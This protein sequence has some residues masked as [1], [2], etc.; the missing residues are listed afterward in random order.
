[1]RTFTQ[2]P[3]A[4][5]PATSA[6]SV[7]FSR[8]LL[9][10]R[11]DSRS[12]TSPQRTTGDQ[13]VQR[14]LEKDRRDVGGNPRFGH[15]FGR[16]SIQALPRTESG[17]AEHVTGMPSPLRAGLEA[18]SGFDL[19]GTRVHRNSP[20]PAQ[21]NALAYT[22]GQDIHLGPG[23]DEH[24]AHEGWHVVQQRQG[25]VRRTMQ[26]EGVA[27]N[28]DAGLEQEADQMASRV[29]SHGSSGP[30]DPLPVSPGNAQGSGV[31]QRKIQITG[32]DD[33][34]RKKFLAKINEGSVLKFKMDATGFLEQVDP[35]KTSI[36]VYSKEM[37]AAIAD[38]QTIILNLISKEDSTFID[39]FASGE[40]DYDDMKSLPFNMFR[41]WLLH[42]VTER[43]A[44]PSYE[45]NKATASNAEFLAAHEKGH[46]AQ[47]RQMREWFPKK[48]IKYKSEGFDE[49]SKVV[50][51]AGNGSI[52]Y[53]FD[54]T[55]VK[56]VFKQPIVGGVTKENIISSKIV[57]VR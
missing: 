43:L 55:D 35:A 12:V 38:P 24:L 56:H 39:S 21:V 19:S 25:R 37:A 49:A 51:A 16:I 42:F 20:K 54:F 26:A 22:Q 33:A 11:P 47:E 15:D 13:V 17:G 27:I 28:D 32:L 45:A 1:M 52:N 29:A 36:E 50:D 34:K 9:E 31:A 53:V 2:E 18:L 4:T 48:T 3:A 57:V 7:A 14:R 23:Q 44:I 30:S 41:I 40:V 46:E 6:R 8:P 10:K 5:R